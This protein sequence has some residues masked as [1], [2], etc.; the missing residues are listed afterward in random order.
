MHRLLWV[1]AM[2]LPAF[3]LVLFGMTAVV[4]GAS[5]TGEAVTR[6]T[7]TKPKPSLAPGTAQLWVDPSG[8]S[9]LRRSKPGPWV[10]AEACRSLRAAY[11]AARAGDTVN[12]T[13]GTYTSQTLGVGMKRILFRASGPGR[14][15]FGQ[16]VSAASGVTLRGVSIEA[17]DID[18]NARACSDPDNAIL[19]PCGANQTF[20][21]V[22]V[23]GLNVRNT[24][25]LGI[26]GVGDDFVLKNSEIRNI[27]DNKGFEGGASG[28]VFDHNYWHDIR[29]TNELVHNECAYVDGG[30]RQVWRRNRFVGCP[31]M[32]LFFTNWNGG[33]AYRDVL[34]E[35]NMFGHTLDD[36]QN[37]HVG[38]AVVLGAGANGQN[39][40]VG[41]T[42]RY[43]TFETCV[44]DK[45][46]ASTSDDNGSGRWYGNLGGGW[47]CVPEFVYHH[48]VGTACGP[49]DL[50]ASPHSNSSTARNQVRWYI[51][52]PAADL[53]LKPG[54][55][56][57]GR[58]DPEDFPPTDIDGQRRPI[59]RT[60]DAGADEA[61]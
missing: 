3:V 34:V 51:N 38:C 41:W 2:A 60:P 49:T 31:T 46:S 57:I 7:F 59:G 39:T 28:M 53:H 43:N 24:N 55:R 10:D 44:Y 52:A 33:P 18:A 56:A 9:C 14:P 26:R 23:D 20:V 19:Y 58:G 50:A 6:E 5:E 15:R 47:D 21:D 35:N 17:R 4:A 61:G 32:A 13:D 25:V 12:I 45:G 29:V 22:I 48:N 8:G 42:V 54:A 11:R 36:E 37:V 16:I 1:A 27:I 30:D 40:F